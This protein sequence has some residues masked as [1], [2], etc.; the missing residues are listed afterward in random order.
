MASEP[1]DTP[2]DSTAEAPLLSATPSPPETPTVVADEPREGPPVRIILTLENPTMRGS[3]PG[4]QM[5]A[6]L[7]A[8]LSLHNFS[9][10]TVELSG[11]VPASFEL[12]WSIVGADG[13]AWTPTHLPPPPPRPRKPIPVSI[14]AGATVEYCNLHGISGF[15]RPGDD[16]RHRVLPPGVYDVSVRGVQFEG[17]KE[18]LQSDPVRL[19]V[20]RR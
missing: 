11:V 16:T 20:R 19:E 9:E 14:P 3:D 7:D 8:T 10:S 15:R 12:Q 17:V 1:I 6:R 13:T 5:E 4:V 18:P 2:E